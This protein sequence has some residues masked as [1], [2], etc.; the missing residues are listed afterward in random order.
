M[1]GEENKKMTE[2]L[3][4]AKG[5]LAV[6]YMLFV[7]AIVQGHAGVAKHYADEIKAK[8]DVLLLAAQMQ[9]GLK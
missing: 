9:Q 7:E 8:V 3:D 6:N 5:E 1:T 4:K 2:Y